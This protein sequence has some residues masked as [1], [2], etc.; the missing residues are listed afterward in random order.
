MLQFGTIAPVESL[1][2]P[3]ML[4][5]SDWA[6]AE[7]PLSKTKSSRNE[8]RAKDLKE[9]SWS[10]WHRASVK[11]RWT[12]TCQPTIFFVSDMTSQEVF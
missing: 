6:W 1:T 2:F 12:D 9:N 8:A 4:P 7:K 5:R 11:K 3:E 10:A